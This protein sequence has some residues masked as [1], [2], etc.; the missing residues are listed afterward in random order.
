MDNHPALGIDIGSVSISAVLLE[1]S[2]D[3]RARSYRFHRGKV[4]EALEQTIRDLDPG[5]VSGI[6]R[7]STTSSE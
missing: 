2:G 3:L 7:K 5:V 1:P 6:G 4:R